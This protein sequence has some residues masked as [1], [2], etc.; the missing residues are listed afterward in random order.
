MDDKMD[1]GGGLALESASKISHVII[2]E[3]IMIICS[4]CSVS[5]IYL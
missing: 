4:V 3:A 1:F 5:A 2:I